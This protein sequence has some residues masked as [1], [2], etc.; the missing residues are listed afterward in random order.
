MKR[1]GGNVEV[2]GEEAPHR[3]GLMDGFL[4]LPPFL[5]L[6]KEPR[7]DDRPRHGFAEGVVK[8]GE[9]SSPFGLDAAG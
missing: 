1:E 8:A 4:F 3:E 2:G 9:T 7:S 5:L 6:E